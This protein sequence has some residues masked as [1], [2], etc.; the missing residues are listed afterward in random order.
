[1]SVRIGAIL[2][3]IPAIL[4]AGNNPKRAIAV[5]TS[6]TIIIDGVP[7]EA[8][9]RS[10]ITLTDFL[11][12]DPEEGMPASEPTEVRILYDDDALYIACTMYDSNPAGIF[13]RLARRDEEVDAD[14][15][16]VRIDSYN[17]NQTAFE[18]TLT[19]AGS[20]TDILQYDDARNEDPSWDAVWD[21]ETALHDFGWTAEF[22]IPLRSLRFPERERHTWGVQV[23]RYIPRKV[24]EQHWA[25]IRKRDAGFVSLFGTLEGIEGISSPANLQVL[26]YG[27][28]GLRSL[29]PSVEF[30]NGIDPRSNVGADIKYAPSPGMTIDAT[31]NPDFGQVDADPALLNLTTFETFY[32]ERRPFFVE[33][34]QI[35][36]FSTFGDASGGP[37]LFYTRRIGHSIGIEAPPGTELIRTPQ[38]ATILGAVKMSGKTESGL[39]FGVLEALTS[40]ERA[41]IRDASGNE[42]EFIA[43][44]F[45][46]YS[47]V[48]VRQD[49]LEHSNVGFILTSVNRRG[50]LPANTGGVNWDLTFPGTVY[51]LDGFLA[52]SRTANGA[53]SRANGTMGRATLQQ[54]G[55]EHWRWDVSGDF[56]SRRF[57]INDIG[58]FRRPNDYGASGSLTYREDT[59]SDWYRQWRTTTRFHT[60]YNFDGARLNEDYGISYE[61][62]FTNYYEVDIEAGFSRGWYDDRETEG[63]GL[64]R[65]ADLRR[66]QFAVESDSRLPVVVEA[67]AGISGDARGAR[68]TAVELHVLLRPL[69][70]FNAQLSARYALAER[71]LSWIDTARDAAISPVRFNIAGDRNARSWD[72]TARSSYVITNTLTLQHYA[73]LYVARGSYY[74]TY[75][76][77]GPDVFIPYPF[78]ATDFSYLSFHSNLVLRWEYLPGSTA[79]LVWSH[80]RSG[81]GGPFSTHLAR[82]FGN[83]FEFP[84]EN[85]LLLKVS[86]WLS[87]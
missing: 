24:E 35:F 61:I 44:P 54:I 4:A 28:G 52:G 58:Y 21:A 23:I 27:V 66:I 73:Q 75:R 78:V 45:A 37:G 14:L 67:G 76:M 71:H 11:Q 81:S 17:D 1:M 8:A 13:A 62:L 15:I 60:R 26:P 53:A 65:N 19:A 63:N 48:R 77:A 29:T 82:D 84:H 57:N 74:A 38:Y 5:R 68:E 64:F 32:P 20:K 25:L 56:T 55:G 34:T 16:S 2:A 40:E 86:Y 59:P 31:F 39:S 50:R 46:N 22:R 3:L 72:F 6:E 69:S 10:A 43:E 49:V 18:F 9:W 79:Y 42:S 12:R 70:N 83:V 85:V 51:R 33:G 41:R 87:I 47:L 80:A 30:P 36:K 7:S